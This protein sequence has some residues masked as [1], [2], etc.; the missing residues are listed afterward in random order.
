[1]L[2]TTDATRRSCSSTFSS[3]IPGFRYAPCAPSPHTSPIPAHPFYRILPGP[4]PSPPVHISWLDRSPFLR[5]SPTALTAT[6]DRGFRSARANIPIRSGAWYYE[7]HVL[8]GSSSAGS[9][10]GS[11]EVG[12]PHIRVG[13]GRREALLEAPVG[14]DGYGYGLRDVGG[15]K[16]H[17]SR[18]RAYAGRGFG[19]GDVVGCCIR[20]PEREE[21]EDE[22][23][24]AFVR[25]RRVPIRYKGQLYFEMDEYLPSKEMEALIDREGKLA[26]SALVDS[27][28]TNDD[29]KSKKGSAGA[30]TKTTSSK[31]KAAITEI[32]NTGREL[33]RLANSSISF[34]LNGEPL[35]T[36]FE[37]LHDFTPLRV[38]R[39]GRRADAQVHD[40]GSLGYYPMISLFGRGKVRANF[41]PDF[42]HP[43][44]Q[45]HRGMYERWD[46]A[47][48][49]EARWDERDEAEAV[50]KWRDDEER[51]RVEEVKRVAAEEKRA[52]KK[53][54]KAGEGKVEGEGG[55]ERAMLEVDELEDDG[56]DAVGL[57]V[58]PS[59]IGGV[60]EG[61][62]E[63]K[64]VPDL[65]ASIG[66]QAMEQD[67]PGVA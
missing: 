66:D 1:M 39:V 6:T 51:R 14:S 5:I 48:A 67:T 30:T 24:P 18:P 33:H 55:E 65:P 46:E 31:K 45:G 58:K 4:P 10:Q 36:A 40:D 17:L 23:D 37:D 26:K 41:G 15:E 12:N 3:L 57:E 47:R 49:E 21:V 13:W 29:T 28:P 2:T 63:G 59:G 20:L 50:E 22:S 44:P 53:A 64:P 19:T 27:T 54:A 11:G 52:A 16:V 32:T 43:V 9:A 60:Q 62:A 42:E 38:Q 35:G 56:G 61:Q 8:R 34:T 7:L 25:R